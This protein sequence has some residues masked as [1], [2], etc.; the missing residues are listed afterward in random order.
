MS[1]EGEKNQSTTRKIDFLVRATGKNPAPHA[2][3][4]D[5]VRC[6]THM[7]DVG[8]EGVASVQVVWEKGFGEG[9]D[10]GGKG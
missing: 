2:L 3:E 6:K 7:R 5:S 10:S 1:R 9:N 4:L 8:E